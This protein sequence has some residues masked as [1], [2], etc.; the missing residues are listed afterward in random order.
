M[1]RVTDIQEKKAAARK[2]A[3]AARKGMDQ[4]LREEKSLAI[5]TQLSELLAR[6]IEASAKEQ[7]ACSASNSKPSFCVAVY[8]AFP[9]EVSLRF[10]IAQAYEADVRVAFPCMM[11]AKD[12]LR[13]IMRQVPK[14]E[15]EQGC[16]EFVDSPVKSLSPD[17]ALE[18]CFPE[19]APQ[20]IDM[21]VVPLVAYDD[22]GN[23]LGYGGGNYD[24]FI[25]L[26]NED[27]V[28]VGVAFAEQKLPSIPC[29]KTDAPLPRIIT[30]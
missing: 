2:T 26:L 9:E 10:F 13:M 17:D 24:R 11:K 27:C 14:H 15:W 21:L 29:E 25:P 16:V 28:I 22:Q 20:D 3:L 7:E 1:Q 4:G 5:S 23:R 12:G 30:V 8:S 19:L 18:A 6:S